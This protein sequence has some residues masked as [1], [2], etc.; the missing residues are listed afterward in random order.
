[1][2]PNPSTSHVTPSRWR[3]I[4]ATLTLV[5]ALV[6]S[7]AALPAN[8][9]D[10]G[11]GPGVISGTATASDG[12]PIA[13]VFVGA[14]VSFGEGTAFWATATTD[15][16]GYFEF[17][18]LALGYTYDLQATLSGYQ[19]T[20]HQSPTLTEASPTATANFVFLPFAV[21]VGT[22]GGH[23]TADGVPLA[24]KDVTAYE[25]FTG[26]NVFGVTD[27]N[28]FYQFTGLA[29][30]QWQVSVWAGG[31]YQPLYPTSVQLTDAAPAAAVNFPFVSWPVGTA[32]ISGI[33]TDSATGEPLANAQVSIFAQNPPHSSYAWTDELGAFTVALLPEGTY[34]LNFW[35][36]GYLHAS[37]EVQALADQTVTVDRALVAT[38]ATISGRVTGPDGAP[39][40]GVYVDAHT[41]DGNIGGSTTDENGNYVLSDL[42]A[43]PY[44]LTVGGGL[45]TQQQRVVTPLAN[46][47]V[48][49]D[50]SLVYR[51]TGSLGG[52][53]LLPDGEYYNKPVCAT[54]YSS[55]T[56]KPLGEAVTIGE[57]FGDGSYAFFD[58][59]PGKYT[60][61]FRDC[62]SDPKTK[63]DKVFLGGVKN[64]KDATIV[65]VVAGQDTWDNSVT[66]TPRNN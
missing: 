37:A 54:L 21:G 4:L 63:F 10:I 7:G 2:T 33:V 27:E 47:D 13:G 49:A 36:S 60:V 6:A 43:V 32:S 19:P 48:T 62:D 20:P 61:E 51:T 22:I 58:L 25:N 59:K 1:M 29:N 40:A 53:V 56:K 35:V 14:S 28:G 8:A 5:G 11:T 31:D 16:A 17:T 65:T 46:G 55:K 18:Q 38:N 41:L 39:V 12:Q 15:A 50:F 66:L 57:D 26:Q 30:G 9:V 23:V 34:S 44:T 64:F 52:W 3:S 45:Y 24:G 42:G